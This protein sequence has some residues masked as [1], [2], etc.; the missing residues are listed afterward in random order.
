MR[1]NTSGS[2]PPAEAPIRKHTSRFHEKLG[3]VPHIAVAT[4]NSVARYSDGLRPQRSASLP[5]INEP[6]TVPVSA[7]SG[8]HS[9]TKRGEMWYSAAAPGDTKASVAGF[10]TS[11]TIAATRIADSARW[12][13]VSGLASSDRTCSACELSIR[14]RSIEGTSSPHTAAAKPTRIVI[15]PSHIVAFMPPTP[16]IIAGIPDVLIRTNSTTSMTSPRT[17]RSVPPATATPRPWPG[18]TVLRM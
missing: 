17:T 5:Q 16:S 11:M 2:M 14:L 7:Q 9:A 13:P 18:V 4:K 6:T 3:I 15:M 8:H 1:V 10:I 12:R